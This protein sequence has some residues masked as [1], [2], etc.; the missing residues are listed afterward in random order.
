MVQPEDIKENSS[1][2]NDQKR[3]DGD[4]SSK[5]THALFKSPRRL[6]D[7]RIWGT[8]DTMGETNLYVDHISESVIG[9]PKFQAMSADERKDVCLKAKLCIKCC[10]KNVVFD[11]QHNKNC[12]V[13]RSLKSA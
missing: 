13:N 5:S 7:C 10:D 8:Q 1:R 2:R 3:S 9:C 4:S 12:K 6:E 11:L